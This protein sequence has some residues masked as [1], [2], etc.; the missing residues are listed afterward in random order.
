MYL[1]DT[2]VFSE[3][4]RQR[5]HPGFMQWL[6]DKPENELFVSAITIG[7]IERGIERQRRRDPSFAVSLLAWLE[8]SIVAFDERILPVTMTV[9]RRW[10]QLSSRL[11]HEGVDLLIAATALEHGFTVATRNVRHFAPT[12]VAV[13]NPF[14]RTP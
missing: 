4:Y 11:G 3:L 13:E 9:A 12:G 2:M 5:R 1:I 10:G 7:E 8:R 14:E 6:G